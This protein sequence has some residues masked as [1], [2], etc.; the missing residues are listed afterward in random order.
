[1]EWRHTDGCWGLEVTQPFYVSL[2]LLLGIV[3]E[4]WHNKLR[5]TAVVLNRQKVDFQVRALQ[6]ICM[7]AHRIVCEM[8]KHESMMW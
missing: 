6:N 2:R 7:T 5:H 4:L 8:K 3:L 1:M